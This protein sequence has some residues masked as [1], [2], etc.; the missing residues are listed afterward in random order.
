MARLTKRR[1][2]DTKAIQHLWAA[3]EIIRNQKQIANIDRITKYMSRVHGMHPKETT[4][5]LS[6]AVKDGL[7][8]ET[9]TVGCKGSKAGIEQEGYWLP[10]DEISI[11]KKHSNKQEM[12]T[13]LRFI[14]SRMKER[15]I[16]LNKKG[17]DSKHPMYRRLVH[18]AVDVPTIQ[19]KVNEG[20][21]RS[22]EE[23]KADAQLL[24]HNTVIFYGADSE[25]ADIARMLYKD[26]CHELDE[27]QLC[28]NCFYLSNARPDNWF[29]YPCIPNHELVWAKMKGFGFWPAKVMQKEDNQ[30][31]V[32][33]FGHHHQRAWI[34]SEN[35]QDITV[36]VHRL[37]V[38]RS[39]GWKKACDELELHQRFL[40]EGRF[41]KSKNED[42]GEEEAES[43]ISSTS[44]EQLKV[45]QEPRA[46]KGRR[47]QSVEPKKEVSCPPHSVQVAIERG[48]S[49]KVR[50][51]QSSNIRQVK[52]QSPDSCRCGLL[53]DQHAS[54]Q[55]PSPE[56]EPETE[57]VS[58]SQE[59]P[60]M[61][62]PIERVSVS[63]QTKKLSASSPRML[64]RSTQTTSDGVC[65]SM[66]HDKYTKIF[67]DF[68]DRMKSDHKRE[69]ERVVR[70]ALEKLRSEMEEEKRQAVNKAV[71][72][73]QGDMD[74]K[75][76]QLKEKCK[77]EFV[78]EIKK[79]AAQHKQLISQTKKKQWCYNCEE[80]AMYHCCWN[81]SYCSIKCQQ[82][83]WH[84]EHK[85]TCRR[86]R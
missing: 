7:I 27:L 62:Q 15:A 61:P 8:V 72:S 75:G 3:I 44:N 48:K 1:Q 73:L 23:F 9:L 38:K 85:R 71:A 6:L 63:T 35:I 24:L 13:Y 25:Q 46:K 14:V 11:K 65:Q 32:R 66:C 40:R 79:L 43:S 30:V 80:E 5:Q 52:A 28:K 41:W 67:N 53:L 29:C 16:D 36:N 83:H 81:T 39:M 51:R 21:Y 20:K 59:I 34:P 12:G 69:T 56:P 84:A 86:K 54:A 57:A 55:S 31:D 42:R 33:F 74:R 4:R 78:E 50:S 10:G 76:K 19:E 70:E 58:S 22:Y 68:K 82:E 60:T 77:E 26:T 18:S 64:H 2:A 47:N 45:T 17:K 37:H 49:L